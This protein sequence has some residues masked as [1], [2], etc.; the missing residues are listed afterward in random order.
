MTDLKLTIL[1]LVEFFDKFLNR[2]GLKSLIDI[3]NNLIIMYALT[4]MQI[5][6][7]YN[8]FSKAILV[9]ICRPAMAMI[10]KLATVDKNSATSMIKLY[11]IDLMFNQCFNKTYYGL[12]LG[13]F[14][15]N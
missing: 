11:G 7:E 12:S 5:L 10:I 1:F 13:I 8:Q 2:N 9:N 4:P 3:I 6:I 14:Y 15:D